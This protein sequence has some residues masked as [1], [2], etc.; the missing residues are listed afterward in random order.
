MKLTEQITI[1]KLLISELKDGIEGYDVNSEVYDPEYWNYDVEQGELLL[2]FLT[3][4]KENSPQIYC[5]EVGRGGVGEE[6]MVIHQEFV[7]EPTRE[8]VLHFI[9]GQD[10]GYDDNYCNFSFRPIG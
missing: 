6:D 10:V 8:E 2:K 1:V 9:E 4:Q 5:I 3:R 7:G